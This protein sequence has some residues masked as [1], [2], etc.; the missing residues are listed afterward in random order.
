MS[1]ISTVQ[2]SSVTEFVHSLIIK[3]HDGCTDTP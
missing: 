3:D 1:A 2:F